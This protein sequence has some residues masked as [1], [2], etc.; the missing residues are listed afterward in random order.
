MRKTYNKFSPKV[1][2]IKV[3]IANIIILLTVIIAFSLMFFI[4]PK[5]TISEEEKREL[6]VISPITA[7]NIFSGKTAKE[8]TSYVSDHFPFRSFFISISNKL[9]D[10]R[11]FKIDNVKI[12]GGTPP[13]SKAENESD[14]P[15]ISSNSEISKP[16][17]SE[18]SEEISSS[19]SNSSDNLSESSPQ[20]E[21]TSKETESSSPNEE[22]CN[23]EDVYQ[24]GEQQGYTFIYKDRAMGL[25]G[26]NN[27]MGQWYASV[28]NK[29]HEVLGDDVKIYNMVV[30]TSVDFYIPK[31]YASV[32]QPER[33][34]ID[35]IYNSLGE[36]ITPINV[37]DTLEKHKDEYI[38]FRTDHHWTGLGAYYA[39]V[40]FAKAAG[41]EPIPI[42]S[43]TTRRLDD[44]LGTL[45][46]L[47]KDEK[48]K[49]NPDYVDYYLIDT[50]HKVYR[51]MK[52]SPYYPIE[53]TLHGE[54]A[55]SPNSYSVF[56]HGDFPLIKVKTELNN[57][58]KIAVVKESY[59]NAFAPF[60]VNHYEEVYIVDERY[61][62]LGFID[63]IKQNGINELIF[64]N[65]IMAANTPYHIKNIERIMYQQF[66]PP[67]IEP[68]KT[69]ETTDES[70]SEK[71]SIETAA[72]EENSEKSAETSSS[73]NP[74]EP[75][76]D[77]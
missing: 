7:E 10:M 57:G 70:S 53:T 35:N 30:P 61:F 69:E 51:Y 68:P 37:Y 6:A 74:D 21:E 25:F 49:N 31:K 17:S 45:Y 39:Y 34:S 41:F 33:P 1:Y 15:P 42:E 38:Y 5:E 43:F 14:T 59:G 71:S 19:S 32:S 52:N 20:S 72:P 27:Q 23:D 2:S 3:S 12:H 29:Y 73:T 28:L 8:I 76:D 26:A 24:G 54:Y 77:E 48:L 75:I 11:G 65:N 16:V 60:L 40:E 4:F 58:K 36:G 44:F 47:T 64:V 55:V 67:V 9:E 56:L 66:I 62:Q 22:E 13:I 18:L 63:F 46:N 50:P